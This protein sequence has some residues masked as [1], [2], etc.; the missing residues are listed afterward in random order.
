MWRE[1][2][3]VL[4]LRGALAIFSALGLLVVLGGCATT[5][6]GSGALWNGA[7]AWRNLSKLGNYSY[8][9]SALEAYDFQ[10]QA[11]VQSGSYA[12]RSNYVETLHGQ[13]AAQSWLGISRL[14]LAAGKYYGYVAYPTPKS[15]LRVGWYDLGSSMSQAYSYTLTEY[16]L[17]SNLWTNR[18]GKSTATYTGSCSVAGQSG[19]GYTV[20]F[21]LNPGIGKRSANGTACVDQKTGALLRADFVLH[22]TD[23]TGAP[24]VFQDHFIV[25]AFGGI[26]AL[27]APA[28][29]RPAPKVG[30]SP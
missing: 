18:L 15:G 5:T 30:I 4:T 16:A 23:P 10:A 21:K 19:F 3:F 2:S 11:I 22:A 7:E 6:S 26:A 29:T 27:S 20:H 9:S 1:E 12:S 14:M 28:G 17:L 13:S 25:T 8:T 24:V